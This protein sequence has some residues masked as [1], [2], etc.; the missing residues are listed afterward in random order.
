MSNKGLNRQSDLP[1]RQADIEELLA[2]MD[3][4]LSGLQ[5]QRVADLVETDRSWRE[6]ARQFGA[7]DRLAGLLEPVVPQRDLTDRIVRSAYLSVRRTHRRK[8]LVRAAKFVGSLAAAACII[9]ALRFGGRE[10]Q[11]PPPAVGMEAM[12]ARIAAILKD[13]PEEDRF[14]VQNL[15]L[16]NH[17]DQVDQ[18]QQVRD[19]ADAETLSALVEIEK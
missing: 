2:W 16:F 1:D 7:V 12:K 4:E 11:V 18:Y 5:A 3:G 10:T 19:L 15:T 17:Y 13:V 8:R 14:V 9:L 6:A